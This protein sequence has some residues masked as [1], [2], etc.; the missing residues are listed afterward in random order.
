VYP[1]EHSMKGNVPL[2]TPPSQNSA[3]SDL[4][5]KTSGLDTTLAYS[6]T[7]VEMNEM[8]T[9]TCQSDIGHPPDKRSECDRCCT[10]GWPFGTCRDFGP[11]MA[12]HYRWENDPQAFLIHASR[13]R[14]YPNVVVDMHIAASKGSVTQMACS[15]PD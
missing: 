1:P 15:H 3:C 10:P 5:P 4:L 7:V 12:G 14:G 6:Q 13:R 9:T 11:E 8:G 2:G